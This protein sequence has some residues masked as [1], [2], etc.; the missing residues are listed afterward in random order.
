MSQKYPEFGNFIRSIKAGIKMNQA[1]FVNKL[2]KACNNNMIEKIKRDTGLTKDLDESE[3]KFDESKIKQWMSGINTGYT[4]Y[5]KDS[6]D[7]NGFINFLKPQVKLRKS[8]DKFNEYSENL[9]Y[10]NCETNDRDEF[11]RSV[12]IQFRDI[13]GNPDPTML[14]DEY[15]WDNNEGFHNGIICLNKTFDE[16]INDFLDDLI[17]GNIDPV[18]KYLG[19][20]ATEKYVAKLKS[21]DYTLFEDTL[22]LLREHMVDIL[23][24]LLNNIKPLRIVSLGI[25]NGEK[26]YLLIRNILNVTKQRLEYLPI[27]IS[28]D[29]LKIGINHIKTT[30]G[31]D[32]NKLDI[33]PSEANF[34]DID[35]FFNDSLI[36][37]RRKVEKQNLFLLLGNT[38]GNFEENQ[39]LEKIANVMN[40]GDLLLV[41]N[42][43]KKT[44]NPLTIEEKQT[45]IKMYSSAMDESNLIA[46]LNHAN[47][48]REHGIFERDIIETGYINPHLDNGNCFT[49]FIRFK[50][51]QEVR[52]QVRG[53]N[54]NFPVGRIVT[55]DYS[56]KYTKFALQNMI[57]NLF[58]IKEDFSNKEYGMFLCEKV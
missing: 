40:T 28:R 42:Q 34:M 10:I 31:D 58:E 12:T 7:N 30:L 48:R 18:Y 9:I 47:I 8:Q 55:L 38:L 33:I 11:L 57:S 50:I 26:D 49:V 2:F 20:E 44:N 1:E 51:K 29:M 46:M 54:I 14:T 13:V 35:K 32:K 4:K 36:T 17:K 45:L 15:H 27:D 16:L 21:L 39:L 41:D 56:K 24:H 3:I 25:G 37:S 52:N 19:K 23:P 43:L 5:F 53:K 22:N 6:F